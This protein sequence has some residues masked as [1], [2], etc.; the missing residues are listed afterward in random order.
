MTGTG[1]VRH[2]HSWELIDQAPEETPGV[3]SLERCR[4]CYR[5][6]AT[7][8]FDSPTGSYVDLGGLLADLDAL[9][10]QYAAHIMPEAPMGVTRGLS[11]RSRQWE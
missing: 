10:I 1:A 2:E 8:E 11:N 9:G 5:F 7:I 3:T 6:R 4:G